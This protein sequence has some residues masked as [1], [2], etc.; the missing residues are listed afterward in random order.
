MRSG[1]T[2]LAICFGSGTVK[3]DP[4]RLQNHPRPI[5]SISDN[6]IR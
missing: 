5:V 1:I 6:E 2:D 3:T 4:L